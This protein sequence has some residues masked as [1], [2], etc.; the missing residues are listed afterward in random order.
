[1]PSAVKRTVPVGV[2]APLSG[3]SVAVKVM[4]WPGAAGLT[5]VLRAVVVAGTL[6]TSTDCGPTGAAASLPLK[7]ELPL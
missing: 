2:P 6:G 4:V 7:N 3:L 1:M 5:D